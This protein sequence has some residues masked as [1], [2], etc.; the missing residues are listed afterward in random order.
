MQ[1]LIR[2]LVLVALIF[3]FALLV[4]G[5]PW[6]GQMEDA[7]THQD[8]ARALFEDNAVTLLFLGLLLATGLVGG[9]YIAKNE[10][11]VGPP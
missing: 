2:N 9:V 6:R 3:S 8:V 10:P 7:P 5:N 4:L 11:E 1:P